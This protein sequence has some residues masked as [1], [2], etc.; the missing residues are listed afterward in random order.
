MLTKKNIKIRMHIDL[1]LHSYYLG[2]SSAWEL[3]KSQEERAEQPQ[4]GVNQY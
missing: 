3:M 2:N 1:K 4:G